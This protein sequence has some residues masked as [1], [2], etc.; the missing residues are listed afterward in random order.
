MFAQKVCEKYDVCLEELRSCSRRNVV[1][2]GR[3]AMSWIGAEGVAIPVLMLPDILKWRTLAWREWYQLP[4]PIQI[5]ACPKIWPRQLSPEHLLWTKNPASP[6]CRQGNRLP[7]KNRFSIASLD[8]FWWKRWIRSFSSKQ[9]ISCRRHW[10]KCLSNVSMAMFNSRSCARPASS[11]SF[12]R[13]SF[14]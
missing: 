2:Q 9:S 7:W 1:V 6:L 3:G 12:L 11:R 4:C 10:A 14:E 8:V 5:Q 13:I